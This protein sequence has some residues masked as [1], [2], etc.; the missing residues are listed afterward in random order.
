LVGALPALLAVAIRWRLKEP[1]QWQKV[2]H[3]GAVAKQ[4]G[5]Y[6]EL[7]RNAT[8]RKHAFVGL[9]L[10]CCGVIGLWAI[11][12]FTPQ[13]TE[14]VLRTR[15]TAQVY[16]EQTEAALARP[17]DTTTSQRATQLQEL[18][19]LLAERQKVPL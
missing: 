1:E 5:S 9:A 11:G 12:F 2:S 17:D 13:L 3:E 15:V 10:A 14:L 7:F 16:E 6:R 4:L 19:G 8:W 18:G